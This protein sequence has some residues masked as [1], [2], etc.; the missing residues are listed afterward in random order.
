M[1]H[2]QKTFGLVVWLGNNNSLV[3]NRS[4]RSW[5]EEYC[6]ESQRESF[7]GGLRGDFHSYSA[8]DDPAV[9][10][11][12][13]QPFTVEGRNSYRNSSRYRSIAGRV[14]FGNVY[15]YGV[16]HGLDHHGSV[17]VLVLDLDTGDF[18]S[19][20]AGMFEVPEGWIW[21]AI[22]AFALGMSSLRFMRSLVNAGKWAFF[23]LYCLIIGVGAVVL[24]MVM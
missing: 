20:I 7:A 22:I 3:R 13:E 2:A 8:A 15:S 21:G 14:S 18:G 10:A 23:G 1:V 9:P 4:N 16:V 11:V 6:R 17:Q 24:S 12:E 19:Y 5:P